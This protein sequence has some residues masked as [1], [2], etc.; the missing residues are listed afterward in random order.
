MRAVTWFLIVACFVAVASVT[1]AATVLFVAPDGND[2]W[3]G[4]LPA[5]NA[6]KTDGP[7]STLSAARDRLRTV[8]KD[9]DCS[10]IVRGGTYELPDTL[11]FGPEDSGAPGHPITYSTYGSERATLTGGRAITGW[12]KDGKLWVANVPQDKGRWYFAQLFINGKLQRRSWEPDETNW[13]KWPVTTRGLPHNELH[14]PEEA[15]D[16][17]YPDTLIKNWPN[18][19]DVEVTILAQFRWANNVTPLKSVDEK[20]RHAVLA[21]P[22]SYNVNAND[23]FRVENTLEGIDEP[24]EWCL[25]TKEGKIYLLAPDGLD[26]AHA[27]FIAPKLCTLMRFQGDES[28]KHLVHDIVFRGFT[29][30]GANRLQ[31]DEL[32]Q[33]QHVGNFSASNSAFVLD[34]V[35]NCTIEDCRFV[36]LA[37]NAIELTH[38]AQ[39]NRIVNNEI[40]GAGGCGVRLRGYAPGT[41][42]LNKHNIIERNHIHDTASDFWASPAIEVWQSGENSISYNYIHD[43]GYVG[44]SLGGNWY[45]NFRLWKGKPDHGFRWNEIPADDPLTRES[46][47]KYL[48][49]RNN[50][51]S[52]N[53]IHDHIKVGFVDGGGIYTV[54]FGKGNQLLNNLI[55]HAPIERS[56]GISLD[57]QSDFM[58]VAGNIIFGCATAASNSDSFSKSTEEH[59][60]YG[61]ETN[62]WE[63]NFIYGQMFPGAPPNQGDAPP[64]TILHSAEIMTKLAQQETGPSWAHDQ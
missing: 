52:Y 6:Q 18:L 46:V 19:H 3:S 55:Y 63:N 11:V 50:V 60:V 20:A 14:K 29:F 22:A 31:Q 30:N 44:I 51:V 38:F 21:A 33:P 13:K 59:P 45:E 39:H 5:A 25:N 53:V 58:T 54:S 37:A 2:A 35:E 56:F 32:E 42:D 8:P 47:K 9:D 15:I 64:A 62:K 48:H 24:G 27:Q 17:Y 23:P 28:A 12:R 26:V 7:L 34:G 41:T 40:A 61:N 10:V 43:V 1:N 57:H 49:T 16:L 4:E 36:G